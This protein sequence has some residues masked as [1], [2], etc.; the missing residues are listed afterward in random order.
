LRWAGGNEDPDIFRYA[1]STAS[2]PPKGAN[3]GHYSNPEVDRLIAEASASTDREL[4]EKDY[5]LVQQILSTE[6]PSINLWYLDTVVVHNQRLS[7]IKLSSSGDYEFLRDAVVA[8]S[9][10]SLH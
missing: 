1:Y 2:F 8:D 7:N 10:T 3:R 6:L 5:Q 9:T 4:R